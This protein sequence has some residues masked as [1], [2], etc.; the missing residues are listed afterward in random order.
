MT[1]CYN[2]VSCFLVGPEV[3][4]IIGILVNNGIP[5]T[6]K[7][8][9]HATLIYDERTFDEPLAELDY[10]QE[11]KA[12]I[13]RLEVLGEGLVFHLYSAAM[14]KEYQRLVD[15]GY[16]HS[17][18]SPMPHMSLTYDFDKYDILKLEQAFSDWAGREL[19][20]SRTSFGTK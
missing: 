5:P 2:Y 8:D 6:P 3:E 16:V 10:N 1:I 20:F 19:T 15:S 4:E 14:V 13:T 7:H 17:F 9:L 18:P 11:F 12:N